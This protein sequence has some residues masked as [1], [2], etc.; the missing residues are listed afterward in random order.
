V[1]FLERGCSCSGINQ[2]FRRSRRRDIHLDHAVAG[3]TRGHTSYQ[4]N[5]HVLI[6]LPPW[7]RLLQILRREFLANESTWDFLK[8]WR[9]SR[10]ALEWLPRRHSLEVRGP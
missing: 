9:T 6:A 8:A 5:H 3:Q 4:S 10:G 7:H 1:P 2:C